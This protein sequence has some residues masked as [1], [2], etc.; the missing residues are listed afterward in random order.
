MGL[1]S[2]VNKKRRK[3]QGSGYYQPTGMSGLLG[4]MFLSSSDRKRQ[5]YGSQ[6]PYPGHPAYGYSNQQPFHTAAAP[7][8]QHDIP[9]FS[10]NT[11]VECP[12]CAHRISQ[13]SKFCPECG[14][15]LAPKRCGQCGAEVPPQSKFCSE[16]GAKQ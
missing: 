10:Q 4:G 12:H 13:S 1:F 7:S 16:C 2:S 5:A 15:Q 3:H 11:L 6:T 9:V 8:K 14:A